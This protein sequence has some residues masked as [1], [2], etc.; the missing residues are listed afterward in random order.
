MSAVS[1][2]AVLHARFAFAAL[3]LRLDEE[4]GTL[5]GLSWDD[6]VLLSALDAAG[7]VLPTRELASRIGLSASALVVRLLP[8]EKTGLVERQTTPAG[9]RAVSMRGPG[10]RLLCEARDTAQHVCA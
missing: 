8:L 1:L 6:F 4:L 5:H 10:R 7:G 2:D 9:D 3:Q